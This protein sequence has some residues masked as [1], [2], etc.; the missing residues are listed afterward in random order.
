V[1]AIKGLHKWDTPNTFPRSSI[2]TTHG[3]PVSMATPT[4]PAPKKPR[5]ARLPTDTRDDVLDT[6]SSGE[7]TPTH[8]CMHPNTT[9]NKSCKPLACSL[10]PN[11]IQL[12]DNEYQELYLDIETAY[13]HTPHHTPFCF[14]APA[15]RLFNSAHVQEYDPDIAELRAHKVDL[16]SL[17]RIEYRCPK[18]R[19]C[20]DCR[21]SL[22]TK[23]VS[24][25]EEAEDAQIK[26]S[27]MLDHENKRFICHLPLR[28]KPEEFLSTNK[29][30]AKRT[31]A[32]QVN[33]YHKEDETKN[34]I[35]K[36]MGKLL[37][38][39]HVSLLKDLP[40]DQQDMILDAPSSPGG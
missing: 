11:N 40:K 33:L 34:L 24:L 14:S 31:L 27:V 22:N 12:N 37:T 20:H 3:A 8:S 35:I 29:D 23:R 39:G 32:R 28:G 21:E 5:K 7:D 17:I 38:N 16:D 18:C 9:P 15:Y 2:C 13:S 30:E 4:A 36:A 26:D 1:T 25:R 10:C 6:S 19:N